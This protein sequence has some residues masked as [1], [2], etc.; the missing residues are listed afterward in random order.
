[1]NKNFR[2]EAE[3]IPPDKLPAPVGWRLLVGMIKIENV[4]SGGILIMD[5]TIEKESY[6]RCIGKVLAVGDD[7]YNH[8]KFQG[9]LDL[10]ERTP[11]HWAKVGDI[12]L[13]GQYTGLKVNLVDDTG[14][15]QAVKLINDDEVLAVI[16]DIQSILT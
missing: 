14:E 5:E 2:F 1:M 9:G 12:V 6:I 3:N 7:C 13:I 10:K 4:S 16:N 11:Q 8:P 15:T